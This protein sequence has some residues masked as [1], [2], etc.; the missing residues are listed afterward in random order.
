MRN[1]FKIF[2]F[3]TLGCF[4][5]LAIILLLCVFGIILHASCL[6]FTTANNYNLSL[7]SAVFRVQID[8]DKDA[9]CFKSNNNDSLND[10]W[11]LFATLFFLES[12]V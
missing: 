6:F 5:S 2:Y 9:D 12:L 3:L 1:I 8:I 4:L 11:L 10:L 7:G